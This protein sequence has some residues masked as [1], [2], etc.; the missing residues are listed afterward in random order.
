MIA[1]SGEV[2]V[3]RIA[4]EARMV[5]VWEGGSERAAKGL[6][7]VLFWTCVVSNPV[8]GL[9]CA[10]L[11]IWISEQTPRLLDRPTNHSHSWHRFP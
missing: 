4:R 11:T 5:E 7:T 10:R 8:D 3:S 2:D 1:T 9:S 6:A